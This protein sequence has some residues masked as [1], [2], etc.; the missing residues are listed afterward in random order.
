MTTVQWQEPQ[1][2]VQ[3]TGAAWEYQP[4]EASIAQLAAGLPEHFSRWKDSRKDKNHPL[5]LALSG[6]GT[7]K[8]RLLDELPSLARHAVCD[9]VELSLAISEG[10]AHVFSVSFENGTRPTGAEGHDASLLIGTRMMWQLARQPGQSWGDFWPKKQYR[11]GDA[12]AE[13]SRLT[14]TPREQQAVFL[15]VDGLQQLQHEPGSKDSVFAGA[16]AEVSNVVNAGPEFVIGAIA[17]TVHCPIDEYLHHSRQ[18]RVYL[19]PPA[20]DGNLVLSA[21]NSL[22]RT[23]IDDMGGHGRALEML[24]EVFA[25]ETDLQYSLA[26]VAGKLRSKLADVYGGWIG[27]ATDKFKPLLGA[28]LAHRR[29]ESRDAL[30]TADW[31][32]EDVIGF[33]LVRWRESGDKSLEVPHILLWLLASHC[34]DPLVGQLGDIHYASEEERLQGEVSVGLQTWQHWEEFVARFISLKSRVFAVDAGVRLDKFHFGAKL[35]PSAAATVIRA[36]PQDVITATK[37]YPSK[38]S[39]DVDLVEHEHGQSSVSAGGVIVINGH[40]AEAGDVFRPVDVELGSDQYLRVNEVSACRRRKS[41]L[42]QSQFGIER[43]KAASDQDIFLMFV[44]GDS[45]VDMA[46]SEHKDGLVD[47]SCLHAYFGPFAGRA[48]AILDAPPNINVAPRSVL[49]SVRGVGESRAAAILQARGDQCF[50]DIDD[51]RRRT[52]IPASILSR[53]SFL[54]DK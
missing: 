37:Q 45:S 10:S 14:G 9:N 50:E 21:D 47:K 53:F 5:F 36:V 13:L 38:S 52:N 27:Q 22:Q 1:R 6:P 46:A 7:G 29:F 31:T 8:S 54:K 48:L 43:E 26:T 44:T 3:T 20:L 23:L 18:K 15:L 4:S 16:L 35:S 39:S 2:L 42:S 51:A 33:G 49:E 24:A 41:S 17:A 40:S 32:V 30:V 19:Q 34:G 12:L 11:I 28:V 25:E